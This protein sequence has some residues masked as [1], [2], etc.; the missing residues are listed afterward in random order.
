MRTSPAAAW[1][2][3]I[4]DSISH[5][6]I[7][8]RTLDS[9]TAGFAQLGG[10][11]LPLPHV[12]MLPLVWIHRST[13][14]ASRAARSAWSAI[15]VA[16]VYIYKTGFGLTKTK[17]PGN[18]RHVGIR[19]EPQRALH[20]EHT[21]D[22]ATACSRRSRRR[23]TTSRSGFRPK[24]IQRDIRIC[25]LSAFA[26]FLGCLT[27]YEAWTITV[28]DGRRRPVRGLAKIGRDAAEGVV[29]S[30][31]FLAGPRRSRCGWVG[32]G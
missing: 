22:R 16:C 2:S 26:A 30:Y 17:L 13:T 20:A 19:A 8:A 24:T 5:L 10:V 29:L 7:A 1:R 23:P 32:T 18:C 27:R 9:P 28:G 25:S 12:L 3:A 14:A 11:W 31:L 21:Y 6:Q 4:A 15:V